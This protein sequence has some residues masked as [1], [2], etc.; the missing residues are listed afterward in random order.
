MGSKLSFSTKYFCCDKK[1]A[2]GSNNCR[3]GNTCNLAAAKIADSKCDPNKK[4]Y[5]G[6]NQCP[7]S[8]SS[9][10]SKVEVWIVV[11]AGVVGLVLVVVVSYYCICR[12]GNSKD[13]NQKKEN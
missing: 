12:K 5:A 10:R 2:C 8:C 4:P 9:K 1:L 6:S 11:V 13:K 3:G 7:K